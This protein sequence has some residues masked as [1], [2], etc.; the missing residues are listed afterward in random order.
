MR[1]LYFNLATQRHTGRT[2]AL[3]E[4]AKTIGGTVVTYY[5]K[6]SKEL[7]QR[8][9]VKSIYLAEAKKLKN[10]RSPLMLDHFTVECLILDYEQE[11]NRLRARIRELE[12]EKQ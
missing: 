11:I 5:H 4:A 6:H 3:C 9:G 12:H 10:P 2:Y 8:Y 1:R 7:K